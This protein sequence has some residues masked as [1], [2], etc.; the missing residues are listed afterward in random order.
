MPRPQVRNRNMTDHLTDDTILLYVTGSHTDGADSHI[1]THL[2][3]CATCRARVDEWRGIASAVYRRAEREAV[4]LPPL[5]LPDLVGAR[6]ASHAHITHD[7]RSDNHTTEGEPPMNI[8]YPLPHPRQNR[9]LH[10]AGIAAALV[11]MFAFVLAMLLNLDPRPP[12]A[13]TM[14]AQDATST[15]QERADIVVAKGEIPRGVLITAGMVEMRAWPLEAAP[16]TALG[17][18]DSVIGK[19]ARSAFFDGQPILSNM[20]TDNPDDLAAV[21][22]TMNTVATTRQPAPI[23]MVNVVVAVQAIQKGRTIAPNSIRLQP[24]PV[25][26]LPTG[27][28]MSTA[29]VIGT[30]ARTDIFVEQ[31]ILSTMIEGEPTGEAAPEESV[32]NLLAEYDDLTT[33]REL[34]DL[35]TEQFQ[36]MLRS[37]AAAFVIAPTDAAFALLNESDMAAL[38]ADSSLLHDFL[39]VYIYPG[40]Q[41]VSRTFSDTSLTLRRMHQLTNGS[42]VLVIGNLIT[43]PDGVLVARTSGG[44]LN[45]ADLLPPGTVAFTLQYPYGAAYAPGD[46]V[47]I[48]TTLCFVEIDGEFQSLRPAA[49]QTCQLVTQT[50]IEGAQVVQVLAS[51]NAANTM[52][53]LAVSP[54]DSAVLAWLTQ[55]SLPVTPVLVESQTLDIP[56][57]HV[58]VTL[59]TDDVNSTAGVDP[60][61][62]LH[63]LATDRQDADEPMQLLTEN[64]LVMSVSA[65][66]GVQ[67]AVLPDVAEAVVGALN[68]GKFITLA[69]TETTQ[70]DEINIVVATQAIRRGSIIPEGAVALIE[71]PADAVPFNSIS[72]IEDVI[73]KRARTDIFV[74]QPILASMVVDNLSNTAP[75][76]FSAGLVLPEGTVAVALPLDPMSSVAYVL[77]S[78]DVVDL[79]VT[80]CFADADEEFQ[81]LIPSQLNL[82]SPP[83]EADLDSMNTADCRRITQRVVQ[84]A[85]VVHVGDFPADSILFEEDATPTPQPRTQPP[86]II[87][88]AVAPEAATILTWMVQA[89]LPMTFVLKETTIGSIPDGQVGVGLG[90]DRFSASGVDTLQAGDH[91]HLEVRQNCF[92]TTTEC[93][94]INPAIWTARAT[95]LEVANQDSPRGIHFT[96]QPDDAL[97]LTHFQEINYVLWML[98]DDELPHVQAGHVLIHIPIN[99]AQVAED[100]P[101]GDAAIIIRESVVT[102]EAV[103]LGELFTPG[104]RGEWRD[105][106]TLT[107]PPLTAQAILHHIRGG[108]TITIVPRDEAEPG[109]A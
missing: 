2:A 6:H 31:P 7:A 75:I 86:D 17:V 59:S 24:W 41:T 43:T 92:V 19:Y 84:N 94:Q 52:I 89:N 79:L 56:D 96:V 77:Q 45:V 72:N 63:L 27:A 53:N 103:F 65:L 98:P 16:F 50:L 46:G 25:D 93:P 55:A 68:Q 109:E 37:N 12:A 29:E 87:T 97:M 49:D 14:A 42:T 44:P 66:N 71:W 22:P 73:E 35:D 4:T 38:H 95:I 13:G 70:S 69:L 23:A 9:A 76:D 48:L 32:Y 15:P 60:G 36:P 90:F 80:L 85:L 20:V 5:E 47:N 78:G 34:I 39:N 64:G 108:G 82:F 10:S 106:V 62:V 104:E 101:M 74:D 18:V 51:D 61:D 11:L 40:N 54:Q 102:R 57:G 105:S 28:M 100:L 58:V 91:V 3:A 33:F 83:D 88:L 26:A 107:L 8:T 21:D 99:Q 67:I 30:T 81:W 1:E